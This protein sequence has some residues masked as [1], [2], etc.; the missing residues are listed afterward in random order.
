M[1]LK[2]I[3]STDVEIVQPDASIQEAAEKMRSL[4]IGALPVSTDVD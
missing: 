3:M 4:D 2:D 1:K